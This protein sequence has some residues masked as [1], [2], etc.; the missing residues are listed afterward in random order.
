[1][2]RSVIASF[3]VSGDMVYCRNHVRIT[4]ELGSIL[5]VGIDGQVAWFLV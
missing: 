5:T 4:C 2:G 1:M 3:E